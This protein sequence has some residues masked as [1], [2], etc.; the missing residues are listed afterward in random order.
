[1]SCPF[2]GFEKGP[3]KI[4]GPP[5]SPRARVYFP[6]GR[7]ELTDRLNVAD[8]SAKMPSNPLMP[9]T[10]AGRSPGAV[11]LVV[12]GLGFVLNL[13]TFAERI[14]TKISLFGGSLP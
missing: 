4:G 10:K 2:A 14:F 9:W 13:L 8:R 6:K 11:A 5:L 3:P 1:M 7:T 12:V